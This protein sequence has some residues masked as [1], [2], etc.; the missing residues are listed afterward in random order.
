MS[1]ALQLKTSA[2]HITRPI[3]SRNATS[4]AA[5]ATGLVQ[6]QPHAKQGA[7]AAGCTLAPAGANIRANP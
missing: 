3:T 4:A 2:D 5:D 7:Y 1:G 6:C